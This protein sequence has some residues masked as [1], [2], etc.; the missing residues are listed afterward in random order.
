MEDGFVD[1]KRIQTI[2][3][4]GLTYLTD[5]GEEAFID[6]RV[7]HTN[8]FNRHTTPKNIEQMKAW[9]PQDNWDEDGVKEYIERVKSW[10]KVANRNILELYIEFYTDPPIRFDFATVEE[11]HAV[12]SRLEKL[13]WYTFDLT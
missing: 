2:T 4:E 13:K 3:A 5:D 11:F 7:C 8:D 10:R 12:R 9:N 1:G 6:F